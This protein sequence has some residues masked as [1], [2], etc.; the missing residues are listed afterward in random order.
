MTSFGRLT[1]LFIVI[2]A[3]YFL[4]QSEQL[5]AGWKTEEDAA[6]EISLSES[7]RD[8]KDAEHQMES[9]T[10]VKALCNDKLKPSLSQELHDHMTVE[11][12]GEII[13]LLNEYDIVEVENLAL[14]GKNGEL[15][16][17]LKGMVDDRI[18]VEIQV[19]E[20]SLKQRRFRHEILK[21]NVSLCELRREVVALERMVVELDKNNNEVRRLLQ[22]PQILDVFTKDQLVALQNEKRKRR[23]GVGDRNEIPPVVLISEHVLKRTL[24]GLQAMRSIA[25]SYETQVHPIFVALTALTVYTFSLLILVAIGIQ[26]SRPPPLSHILVYTDALCALLSL[27]LAIGRKVMGVDPL[28]VLF[29]LALGAFESLQLIWILSYVALIAIRVVRA[30]RALDWSSMLQLILTFLVAHHFYACVW[31]DAEHKLKYSDD[32]AHY[33]LYALVHSVLLFWQRPKASKWTFGLAQQL[34]KI[35]SRIRGSSSSTEPQRTG[36]SEVKEDSEDLYGNLI[37]NRPNMYF[38]GSKSA[39]RNVLR[40]ERPAY[41]PVALRNGKSINTH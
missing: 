25:H 35:I 12:C 31:V 41:V 16:K 27:G 5:C 1:L 26:I 19:K 30:S 24:D 6:K 18:A 23:V 17:K 36:P 29:D 9:F 2:F 40:K 14:D 15:D 10:Y 32:R 38:N 39:E 34:G 4:F 11:L 7:G 22:K 8:I 20:S 21:A 37:L 3:V 13:A 28:I 33:E